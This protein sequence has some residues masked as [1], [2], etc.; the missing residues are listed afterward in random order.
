MLCLLMYYI[1]Y[2]CKEQVIECQHCC[3]YPS[4]CAFQSGLMNVG[5]LFLSKLKP[6][7]SMEV[8][9]LNRGNWHKLRSDSFILNMPASLT[10]L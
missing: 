10:A 6:S 2:R 7:I 8:L 9:S 3:Y 4:V 5:P 1:L